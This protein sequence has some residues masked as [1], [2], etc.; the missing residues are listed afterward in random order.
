MV[1]CRAVQTGA[2]WLTAI[3]TLVAGTPHFVCRCPNGNVKPFCFAFLSGKNGGCCDGSCCSASQVDEGKGFAAL[4]SFSATGI[5]KSCCCC[6][7]HQEKASDPSRT[8]A[9][10]GN[11][12]CQKVLVDGIAA[13][14][15]PSVQAPLQDL[16]AHLFVPAPE[17]TMAQ[18]GF[19]ACDSAFANRCHWPPPSTDLVTVLQRFLI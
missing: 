9:N 5:K 13:V 16:T 12:R 3:M 8:D 7:T 17:T 2:V 11:A 19:G 15:A 10:L 1:F 14:P 6:K 4:A 18:E